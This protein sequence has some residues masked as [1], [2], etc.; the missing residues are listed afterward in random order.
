MD[1]ISNLIAHIVAWWQIVEIMGV[2]H[3]SDTNHTG[4]AVLLIS[5]MLVIWVWT[6]EAG[7]MVGYVTRIWPCSSSQIY[8]GHVTLARRELVRWASWSGHGYSSTVW[9]TAL[10]KSER[11]SGQYITIK[12]R[13]VHSVSRSTIYIKVRGNHLVSTI[14]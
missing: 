9:T 12:A 7:W 1:T 3:S 6:W 14:I 11:R 8:A 10:Y 4:W 5:L 13:K 2:H